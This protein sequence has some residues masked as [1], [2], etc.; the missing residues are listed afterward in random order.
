MS[1]QRTNDI[2]VR[3]S[4]LGEAD[5]YYAQHKQTGTFAYEDTPQKARDAVKERLLRSTDCITTD[6]WNEQIG[7]RL[8]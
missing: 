3:T 5:R 4:M 8:I 1:K 6:H 2:T 7:V